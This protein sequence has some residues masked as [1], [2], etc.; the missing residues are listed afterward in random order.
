MALLKKGMD[1]MNKL[2]RALITFV[3]L[4]SA[5][6]PK[7]ESVWVVGLALVSVLYVS[8]R[9]RPDLPAFSESNSQDHDF[10]NPA[11]LA[12]EGFSDVVVLLKG[13]QLSE[14]FVKGE[15]GE[16]Y[17]LARQVIS[18]H[19]FSVKR[20]TQ[21]TTSHV[22]PENVCVMPAVKVRVYQWQGEVFLGFFSLEE[23]WR[24]SKLS[25][26][27]LMD[28]ERIHEYPSCGMGRILYQ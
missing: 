9:S 3:M 20:P 17:G 10:W 5:R 23:A 8:L 1:F 26:V 27:Y 6:R 19:T 7:A 13:T 14:A 25:S 16:V 15:V 28:V 4:I 18:E 24:T 22:L 12:T 2:F 11:D 21:F